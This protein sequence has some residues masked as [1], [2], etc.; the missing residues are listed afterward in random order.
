MTENNLQYFSIISS[1]KNVNARIGPLNKQKSTY[2]NKNSKTKI[3]KKISKNKSVSATSISAT[4]SANKLTS[5]SSSKISSNIGIGLVHP[6]TKLLEKLAVSVSNYSKECNL[7]KNLSAPTLIHLNNEEY[8]ERNRYISNENFD[9]KQ[10]AVKKNLKN[11]KKKYLSRLSSNE[12]INVTIPLST[13]SDG[14]KS[15]KSR[16]EKIIRKK[17]VKED[18]LFRIVEAPKYFVEG[19]SDV[20]EDDNNIC[21]ND[22]T[23]LCSSLQKPKIVDLNATS[24]ELITLN[25]TGLLPLPPVSSTEN[26]QLTREISSVVSSLSSLHN[27]SN[28]LEDSESLNMESESYD[29]SKIE[30]FNENTLLIKETIYGEIDQDKI[31]NFETSDNTPEESDLTREI[32]KNS[33][34]NVTY[35]NSDTRLSKINSDTTLATKIYLIE[36]QKL[37]KEVFRLLKREGYISSEN[38]IQKLLFSSSSIVNYPFSI[39]VVIKCLG[40][41]N[42]IYPFVG[43]DHSNID[44]CK[45]ISTCSNQYGSNV[46]TSYSKNSLIQ[47]LL[48]LTTPNITEQVSINLNYFIK[49]GVIN[50]LLKW[51]SVLISK[52][53]NFLVNESLIFDILEVL[54][55]LG[56]FEAKISVYA[57][58]NN[59]IKP[60]ITFLEEIFVIYLNSK[61][62][63]RLVAINMEEYGEKKYNEDYISDVIKSD[64][65]EANVLILIKAGAVNFAS[66][67]ILERVHY[68]ITPQLE[69]IM[70]ELQDLDDNLTVVLD[71]FGILAKG[72]S[73]EVIKSLIP[74]SIASCLDVSDGFPIKFLIM[75]LTILLNNS[76]ITTNIKLKKNGSNESLK[77]ENLNN[78]GGSSGS[79]NCSKTNNVFKEQILTNTPPSNEGDKNSTILINL[80]VIKSILRI[81]IDVSKNE[82]FYKILKDF[83]F[84]VTLID[85]LLRPDFTDPQLPSQVNSQQNS[86]T[87]LFE[88]QKP[89]DMKKCMLKPP[90][91]RLCTVTTQSLQLLRILIPPVAL[92][93]IEKIL[94]DKYEIDENCSSELTEKEKLH[95]NFFFPEIDELGS[96]FSEEINLKSLSIN[97]ILFQ[98]KTIL[99]KKVIKAASGSFKN[100]FQKQGKKSNQSELK[101]LSFETIYDFAN[102]SEHYTPS[103]GRLVYNHRDCGVKRN[104]SDLEFD[105]SFESGNLALA[106]KISEFRYQLVINSDVNTSMGKHNQWFY[107]SCK[108]MK[109]RVTYTFTIINMSKSNSQLN[110]GMQP[111]FFSTLQNSWMRV[112]EEVYYYKNHYYKNPPSENFIDSADELYSSFTFQFQFPNSDDMCYFAYHYP[113]TY[114]NLQCLLDNISSNNFITRQLLCETVGGHRCDLLTIT[115][116]D[117][118][119]NLRK[120]LSERC[121][122]YLSARV[123]PDGV[124]VGNHRTSLAGLDLN[125][126]WKSPKKNESPTIFW[127]KNLIGHLCNV[128]GNKPLLCC[129]IHGHS[130]K[131]NVFIFGNDISKEGNFDHIFPT[132][133]SNICSS[134]DLNNCLYT[135]DP[136]KEG[137]ARVVWYKEFGISSSYTLESSYCGATV[138]EYKGFQKYESILLSFHLKRHNIT[139][140]YAALA[141]L[142]HLKRPYFIEAQPESLQKQH[143]SKELKK[144]QKSRVK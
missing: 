104:S 26:K 60:L 58:L 140:E 78:L 116:T 57:R 108:N 124:I 36:I 128:I 55:R 51:L 131:K 101:R 12:R 80:N 107:F 112:G 118:E 28:S 61:I 88:F 96:M 75:L 47:I 2:L 66:Q 109:P 22:D 48:I 10:V 8:M 73:T 46:F 97:E 38:C 17:S 39:F 115:A 45:T 33:L 68:S 77:K 125:R 117:V 134:F 123:H 79:I 99:K 100:S 40:I 84:H 6:L 14:F 72:R 5:N 82:N 85:Y 65:K 132:I 56:K 35:T 59:C 129:D 114:T 71:V 74:K 32:L 50:Q 138:G 34:E 42:E 23:Q 95:L 44:Q 52:K 9:E 29:F 24:Q 31:S 130:R 91:K 11:T 120:P 139:L 144:L 67:V 137:T 43:E 106:I 3:K 126:Q 122:I 105:S 110:F 89:V 102:I 19:D 141:R 21:F 62:E 63:K 18:D 41:A 27:S 70:D 69:I 98:N 15:Q 121:Y 111:V 127:A 7:Q 64:K 13:C 135:N 86:S 49:K 87:N 81:L 94:V 30:N 103:A 133:L 25:I 83:R 113:Y 119:S 37:L 136:A 16:K 143:L 93:F 76:C 90:I 20:K 1:Y 54:K 142:S 4:S 53:E 92:P